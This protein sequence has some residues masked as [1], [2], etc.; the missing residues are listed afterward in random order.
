MITD[1]NKLRMRIDDSG[2]LEIVDPDLSALPLLR[3]LDPSYEIHTAPL[4]GF[5]RP[6]L[7]ECLDTGLGITNKDIM[8][9][10][11]DGL[12]NAHEAGMTVLQDKDAPSSWRVGFC[13]LLD[14]KV[15]LARRIL[16]QCR[17]CGRRCDVDR[18]AGEVGACGLGVDGIIAKYS[19]HIAEEAPINPSLLV[20]LAGCGLRCKYCQQGLLQDASLVDG[21][22]LSAPVWQELPAT[23]ARSL[24]FIG[25]NPDEST[26]AILN[27]LRSV[28]EDWSLP[29][30]WNCHAF[31]TPATLALLD[32]I[33][34]CY[35]PDFRYGSAE[36]GKR[37]SGIEDYPQVAE[38]CI[39]L[40]LKQCVPVICRLLVLPGHAECC[41]VPI[42]NRLAALNGP[43]LHV[44]IRDQYCPDW[45]ISSEDGVLAGRPTSEEV[46]R[47]HALACEMGLETIVSNRTARESLLVENATGETL[48]S[49]QRRSPSELESYKIEGRYNEA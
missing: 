11:D 30:V 22:A 13:S 5:S 39:R 14:V 36:C 32:G 4:P 18:T 26:Y 6:R 43:N 28:P 1:G 8:S 49:D 47:L 9:M 29:I 21:V 38:E 34:D 44:S 27:F 2:R 35:V 15:E 37:L 31:S 19:V 10:D 7:L 46:L 48:S 23:E 40:M 33:V 3:E 17:L 41:Q 20:S 12:W 24:A 42:L 16:K 25:G 45:R